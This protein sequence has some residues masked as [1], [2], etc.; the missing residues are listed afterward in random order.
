MARPVARIRVPGSE[1][2]RPTSHRL[3]GPLPA[4]ERLGVTLVVRPAPGSPA[5]PT[6]EDWQKTPL[7]ER[8][9]LTPEAYAKR[10]GA[11]PAD[12]A[13]VEAFARANGL[14]VSESHAGRRTVTVVGTAGQMNAA[15]GVTLQRFE[16]PVPSAPRARQHGVHPS[17]ESAE[18]PPQTHVHHGFDGAVTIPGELAGIVHAVVGL[19]DRRLSASAGGTGDPSGAARVE[20][21]T[22][23]GWYNFPNT[24]AKDQ[25]I[26]VFAP[27]PAAYLQSDITNGYFP[28]LTDASY[29]SAPTMN[30]IDLTVGSTT[31]SNSATSVQAITSATPNATL[32]AQPDSY[33][34]ELTQ[35]VSTSSTIAQGCTVN[36][37]FTTDTEQGWQVFLNRILQPQSEA[38]PTVVTASFVLNFEDSAIGSPTDSGSTAGVLSP[39]F[40]AC[41]AQ[42]IDVF[43]ALGDWGAD[44]RQT[45]GKIHVG[46]CSTDPWVTS[47][48]GTVAVKSGST[49]TEVVWS[50]AF[51][52]TSPFGGGSPASDFGATGGGVSAAWT[53]APA[54]QTAIGVTGATD[55]GGTAHTGRGVPDVAGMVGYNGFVINAANPSPLN[56]N[57]VGTSCVAPLYAGLAAVLRSAFGRAIGPFNTT[58]YSLAS[59]AFNDVTSG[60]NDSGDTPDSPFFTAG[61]GWDACTGLGSIDGTKLLNGVASELYTP[62]WYFQVSKGSFGLDEVKVSGPF[63]NILWLV[64][65]GYTPAAVTAAGLTPTVSVPLGGITVSVGAAQPEL[66]S[67]TSTPQRILFPCTVTFDASKVKDVAQGGIFPD[68]GDAAT[69]IPITSIITFA[70]QI[71][72]A[73]TVF[74]LEAGADPGFA[75]YATSGP[76]SVDTQANNPFWLSQD[77][78][79]FTLTPGINAAPIDGAVTLSV[80]DNTSYH[81][82]Q[83][84]TYITQLL[85]HLNSAYSNPG[86]TD[87]FTLFPDQTNALSA[88]SSVT[89][90]Q[91]N[92]ANLGGPPFVNYNFAVARVRLTDATGATTPKPVKVFFRLFAA[93]TSDTDYQPA[94]TYPSNF[95]GG[96]PESPLPG[97]NDVT[98]PFFA[99]G[100]YETSPVN[101]DYSA[102]SINNQL[103]TVTSGN[104]VWAYY[105][106]YLNI[107]GKDNTIGGKQIQKLLPSTHSCVVA[108]I[109]YDDAPIP[110]SGQV[111]GPENS[112]KLAQ[113]NLQITFSD[114][115]GPAEAHRVPQTFD[116]RRGPAPGADPEAQLTQRPDELMIEWGSV[117][118][119]S[120]ASI[121]WPAVD[122]QDV[123]DVASQLYSTHQL[124]AQDAH[125]LKVVVPSGGRTFVPIPASPGD[126]LAGL[127]TVELPVGVKAG[128]NF[129]VSVRRIT[130]LQGAAPPPPPPPPPQIQS[131]TAAARSAAAQQGPGRVTRAWRQVVGTFAVRIPVTTA[132]VMRPVEENTLAIMKWRL[133][134]MDPTN[135]WLPVLQRYI[136][137]L[138]GRVRGVHGDPGKIPPSEWG[139]WG[140][141]RPSEPGHGPG[142]HPQPRPGRD[143]RRWTEHTGKIEGLVFD[144]FGDFEG[145]LLRSEDGEERFF[146][147][148]EAEIEDLARFAWEQRV[149]VTVITEGEDWDEVARL[150][151]R[152]RPG[153]RPRRDGF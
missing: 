1:R 150:V 135:R 30:D 20:V 111:V 35:D 34:L 50:D 127:F 53:T 120:V 12:I 61:A 24:G 140:E 78:R 77:L 10:H 113:R 103:I 27:N 137:L 26:G 17:A 124:A 43:I 52:T 11:A 88:D 149:R 118:T 9:Y 106:C 108:Q 28:G 129:V 153:S 142:R 99:T 152:Q 93:E 73:A 151:L 105:G 107:Y 5:L 91:P 128:E 147:S 48:G 42:G 148:R 33:I 144:R 100:N 8:R 69:Q 75:N 16:A 65:E 114:N 96:L 44:N 22:I 138:E 86:G 59:S 80:P 31:F 136:G 119:G 2:P 55:S 23:A 37:Y 89:P 139:I 92:P 15:F 38:Q 7:R 62:N 126:N 109:A 145:L 84:Y 25:V 122:A 110:T 21:P 18:P 60:N 81:T 102:A 115:P 116:V 97:V 131:R 85:Q 94:L 132:A 47:C 112:D 63:I 95:T 82:A 46:Y 36:V 130:T 72:T 14:Q 40:Q 90:T 45:D 64:L 125:T 83:A 71:L 57:F 117:P 76:P 13:A 70:S 54:Y 146:A 87:P 32:N 79:V 67:D 121:Y 39:L 66:A 141:P 41:A 29:H 101:S 104:T 3:L 68:P 143:H 74:D 134:Q 56:Y 19:D 49:L 4:E 58:L 51:S 123:L 133:Q 6:L 98:L